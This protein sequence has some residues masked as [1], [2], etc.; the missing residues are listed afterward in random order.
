VKLKNQFKRKIPESP[1]ACINEAYRYYNNAKE[2]LNK[3]PIEDN[4]YTDVKKLLK[5]YAIGY[6]SV[7]LAIDVFLL[8][9]GVSLADLPTSLEGYLSAID[10]YLYR[11]RTF[12]RQFTVVYQNLHIFG[13][14]RGA[15][16]VAM[17]KSGFKNAKMIIDYFAKLIK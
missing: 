13:Y 16:D 5:A 14:Y 17:I 1:Q 10:K 11:N 4:T 15:I 3:I 7:L 12:T 9:K 6:L 8:N 2:I